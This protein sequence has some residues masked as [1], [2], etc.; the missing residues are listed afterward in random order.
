MQNLRRLI[1][2]SHHGH[3]TLLKHAANPQR[4]EY[5]YKVTKTVRHWS[6]LHVLLQPDWKIF[7]FRTSYASSIKLC[8]LSY[9]ATTS[10]AHSIIPQGRKHDQ[11]RAKQTGTAHKFSRT[12]T[13]QQYYY[14]S[15]LD[16]FFSARNDTYRQSGII[17]ELKIDFRETSLFQS[18]MWF[19][20]KQK[21]ISTSIFGAKI[22][23]A[24][25]GSHRGYS[26]K[27]APSNI[28][29]TVFYRVKLRLTQITF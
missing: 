7:F 9:A 21:K 28:F 1:R 11:A 5:M 27:Q 29:P 10:E 6:Q 20:H 16:A 12:I 22:L 13:A 8:C 19:S 4:W 3:G 14:I 18:I 15:F 25:D 26:L 17:T 23:A 2:A 24:A